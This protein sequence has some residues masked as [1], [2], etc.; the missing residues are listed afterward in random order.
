MITEEKVPCIGE[1]VKVTTTVELHWP[2]VYVKFSHANGKEYQGYIDPVDIGRRPRPEV[3]DYAV[4]ISTNFVD[5]DPRFPEQAI[6]LSILDRYF[7]PLKRWEIFQ[8]SIRNRSS[9]FQV[10]RCYREKGSWR[11]EL[12][13]CPFVAW[14]ASANWPVT[15]LTEIEEMI[16]SEDAICQAQLLRFDDSTGNVHVKLVA[17]VE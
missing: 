5:P 15:F 16:A 2:G 12:V 11:L 14:P 10:E 9:Y 7:E 6:R 8:Y 13:N 1:V 4:I 17:F 3:G